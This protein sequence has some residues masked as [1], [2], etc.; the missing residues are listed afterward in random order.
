MNK[1]TPAPTTTKTAIV[2]P[3]AP[4]ALMPVGAA[5]VPT[6]SLLLTLLSDA[7]GCTSLPSL[8][9]GG[10]QMTSTFVQPLA[11]HS[12]CVTEETKPFLQTSSQSD[13][14]VVRAHDPDL[15]F[16]TIRSSNGMHTSSRH[17]RA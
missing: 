2:M 13:P 17:G 14:G 15:T 4:P 16:G 3:T 10:A 1:N 11:V 9:T 6:E 12:I 5:V 7:A 8:L